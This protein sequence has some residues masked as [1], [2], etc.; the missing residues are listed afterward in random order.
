MVKLGTILLV[1]LNVAYERRRMTPGTFVLCAK[2]LMKL[3]LGRSRNMWLTINIVNFFITIWR[4]RV[5]SLSLTFF[6]TWTHSYCSCELWKQLCWSPRFRYLHP[7]PLELLVWHKKH[8]ID[9]YCRMHSSISWKILDKI[10]Q[11]FF[12]FELCAGHKKCCLK[13]LKFTQSTFFQFDIYASQLIC[14]YIQ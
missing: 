4:C 3:T 8:Q 6:H 7:L 2:M 12:Q 1:K 11:I 9:S 5:S 14:E 10:W 13:S